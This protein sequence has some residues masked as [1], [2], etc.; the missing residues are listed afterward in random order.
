MFQT[1]SPGNPSITSDTPHSL[2]SDLPET[3]TGP[4]EMIVSPLSATKRKSVHTPKM[5][6]LKTLF[7]Q[8]KHTSEVKG[9]GI[10]QLLATPKQLKPPASPTGVKEMFQVGTCS[11]FDK[12]TSSFVTMVFFFITV[13]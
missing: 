4:G 1:P 12:N 9:G 11:Q 6:G 10:K 13:M 8:S 5:S 7:S 3:P 2:Y